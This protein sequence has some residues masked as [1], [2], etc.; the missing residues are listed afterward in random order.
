MN[1]GVSDP[2]ELRVHHTTLTPA[3]ILRAPLSGVDATVPAFLAAYKPDTAMLVDVYTGE[4]DQLLSLVQ[5]VFEAGVKALVWVGHGFRGAWGTAEKEGA[6]IRRA[7]GKILARSD[8][9]EAAYGPHYDAAVITNPGSFQ[10]PNGQ[11]CTTAIHMVIS[12]TLVCLVQPIAVPIAPPV[13]EHTTSEWRICDIPQDGGIKAWVIQFSPWAA[14]KLGIGMKPAIFDK[15]LHQ[16]AQDFLTGRQRDAHSYRQL[17]IHL[18]ALLSANSEYRQCSQLFPLEV[19]EMAQAASYFAFVHQAHQLSSAFNSLRAIYGGSFQT[20]NT[21]LAHLD[22]PLP[23]PMWKWYSVSVMALL[24]AWPRMKG[25]LRFAWNLAW[26]WAKRKRLAVAPGSL[27]SSLAHWLPV[28]PPYIFLE[29]LFKHQLWQPGNKPVG[30]VLLVSAEI[31]KHWRQHTLRHYIPTFAMHLITAAMPLNKG[32]VVH[33]LWNLT[34]FVAQAISRRFVSGIWQDFKMAH[35]C[36]P[37]EHRPAIEES[38]KCVAPFD[39]AISWVPRQEAFFPPKEVDPMMPLRVKAT[40]IPREITYAESL[41]RNPVCMVLPTSHPAYVPAKSE[42]NLQ[43]VAVARIMAPPPMDPELQ[44]ERWRTVE[45]IIREQFPP[46][47]WDQIFPLWVAHTREEPKKWKRV[48]NAL[49]KLASVPF[50]PDDHHLSSVKLFVKTNEA[51]LKCSFPEG[52]G[53]GKML[54]KPRAIAE[55]AP[56]VQI[57]CGPYIY[58][59]SKTLAR[60]WHIDHGPHFSWGTLR[61]TFILGSVLVADE[62]D[63]VMQY[64]LAL[65]IMDSTLT[66]VAIMVAGDDSLVCINGRLFLESDFGM[67]D[68]SQSFGPLD[69]ERRNLACLGVPDEILEHLRKLS[70]ATFKLGQWR[71]SRAKRPIRDT[72]GPN[73]SVGNSINTAG[74]WCNVICSLHRPDTPIELLYGERSIADMFDWLGLDAKLRVSTG[75]MGPT[76]LKGMW[77]KTVA[78]SPFDYTWAPLPSR[79]LKVGKILEDPRRTEHIADLRDAAAH[80]LAGLANTYEQ[81]AQVPILSAFVTRY[82]RANVTQ[83]YAERRFKTQP[84]K[85]VCVLDRSSALSQTANHYDCSVNDVLEMEQQFTESVPFCML[86]HPGYILMAKRDYA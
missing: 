6:W 57:A 71:I 31:I 56:E 14:Q 70:H 82:K 80:F 11:W 52:G 45:V 16:M 24:L 2:L 17:V 75:P 64:M 25:V 7:D 85:V 51:L 12:N 28:F 38:V 59:A 1:V 9:Y 49:A 65:S 86:R 58:A 73:T 76:F 32:F 54:L 18:Q 83:N 79:V 5:Q 41:T 42:G 34:I 78:G 63:S 69:Y 53:P 48:E 68:A 8:A 50:T 46:L 84:G 15:R 36:S 23:T 67:Y 19:A 27:L 62:L 43:K 61:F 22:K 37:W 3:D 10:L 39:P 47:V 29:E 74:A 60:H 26:L 66:H 21:S 81:F 40:W 55:V 13:V 77:W 44:R 72:G 35:Y 33:Y 30:L 4:R 20:Y